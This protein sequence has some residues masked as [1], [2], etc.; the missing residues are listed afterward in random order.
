[1][2]KTLKRQRA[3]EAQVTAGLRLPKRQ[4]G[5]PKVAP[6]APGVKAAAPPNPSFLVSQALAARDWGAA[7]AQ[8]DAMRAAGRPPKLGAVQRWVRDAD[9][10]GDE[11]VAAR[12]ICAVLRA[13]GAARTGEAAAA[14][15]GPAAAPSGAK[16]GGGPP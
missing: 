9:A 10:A 3:R 4:K 8:L 15:A 16:G 11:A 7:V 6:A 14:V 1:M 2:G 12:I 13:A 5:A